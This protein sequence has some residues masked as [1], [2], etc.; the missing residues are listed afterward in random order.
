ML[1]YVG[2]V[3]ILFSTIFFVIITP[4]LKKKEE[5]VEKSDP[6]IVK[7]IVVDNVKKLDFLDS[8]SDPKKKMLGISGAILSGIF[9]GNMSNPT[10]FIQ[11]NYPEVSMNNLDH[12]L[13]FQMGILLTSVL[14]FL[15]YCVQK[16]NKPDI[17]KEII[18]PGIISGTLWGIANILLFLSITLISESIARPITATGAK[19]VSSSVGVIVY[20][21]IK[22]YKNLISLFIGFFISTIG[23]ILFALSK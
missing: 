8:L 18:M 16:K 23:I 11:D 7:K 4:N 1:N 17:N 15:A 12:V 3:L 19:I 20:R 13:S 22:G 9:Y 14:F 2:I 10:R 6:F 21:E 5:E